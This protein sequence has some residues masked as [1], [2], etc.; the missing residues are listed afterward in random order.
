MLTKYS[1]ENGISSSRAG[2][3][4]RI[5][6]LGRE[7]THVRGADGFHVQTGL[8]EQGQRYHVLWDCQRFPLRQRG[9][10]RGRPAL[11]CV[12]QRNPVMVFYA[13][14]LYETLLTE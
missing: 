8:Q 6:T 1:I 10:P 9:L 13:I 14:R 11:Q 5:P 7:G 4:D 3:F 2:V 12:Q